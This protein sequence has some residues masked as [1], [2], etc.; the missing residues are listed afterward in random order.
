MRIFLDGERIYVGKLASNT[1]ISKKCQVDIGYPMY[2]GGGLSKSQRKVL[3]IADNAKLIQ[4]LLNTDE[5]SN[6]YQKHAIIE[7]CI[8]KSIKKKVKLSFSHDK[9]TSIICDKEIVKI[10]SIVPSKEDQAFMSPKKDDECQL[11]DELEKEK[12]KFLDELDEGLSSENE[13]ESEWDGDSDDGFKKA[14]KNPQQKKKTKRAKAKAVLNQPIVVPG[15]LQGELSEYE[16]IRADNIKERQDMLAALMANF[17][18]YKQDMG[19]GCKAPTSRK[20]PKVKKKVDPGML[21]RST[22]VLKAYLKVNHINPQEMNIVRKIMETRSEVLEWGE[23]NGMSKVDG[24]LEGASVSGESLFQPQ[25]EEV[26]FESSDS[27]LLKSAGCED[28]AIIYTPTKIRRDF[29]DMYSVHTPSPNF[30]VRNAKESELRRLSAAVH[31]A[32][33]LPTFSL[34]KKRL[35]AK[36]FELIMKFAGPGSALNLL[37]NRTG[38]Q[39]LKIWRNTSKAKDWFRGHELSG[40][41]DSEGFHRPDPPYCPFG[42]CHGKHSSLSTMELDLDLSLL[43]K[44]SIQ[45]FSESSAEANTTVADQQSDENVNDVDVRPKYQI[46]PSHD[47]TCTDVGSDALF[48]TLSESEL[49]KKCKELLG[50]TISLRKKLDFDNDMSTTKNINKNQKL[51][52]RRIDSL[53]DKNPAVKKTLS[54][55]VEIKCHVKGCFKRYSTFNGLSFHLKNCHP[56]GKE[57]TSNNYT[58]KSRCVIC[59][60]EVVALDKHMQNV[61]SKSI[62]K[63]CEECGQQISGSIQTHLDLCRKCKFC[64]KRINRKDRVESHL[65]ACQNRLMKAKKQMSQSSHNSCSTSEESCE[66]DQNLKDKDLNNVRLSGDHKG[67]ENLRMDELQNN[68]MKDPNES[69]DADESPVSQDLCHMDKA[70]SDGLNTG[71]VKGVHIEEFEN[72]ENSVSS[73]LAAEEIVYSLDSENEYGS[74]EDDALMRHIRLHNLPYVKRSPTLSDG[75]CWYDAVA[76]QITLHNIPNKPKDHVR[77][78]SAICRFIPFLPQSS[79]WIENIFGNDRSKFNKFI[80]RHQGDC[81]WTDDY[82]IICQATAL[83]LE[84]NIYIVGT[85]NMGQPTGF[86]IIEGTPESDKYPPLTIGYYQGEHYQSLEERLVFSETNTSGSEK[87]KSED[88][89][90]TVPNT[91]I[92][93]KAEMISHSCEDSVVQVEELGENEG[94]KN[95][96]DEQTARLKIKLEEDPYYRSEHE[97]DDS[98]EFT[99]FRRDNKDKIEKILQDI[100]QKEV[101]SCEGDQEFLDGFYKFLRETKNPHQMT[102]DFASVQEPSTY[103]TYVRC[104]KNDIFPCYRTYITPFD[105]QWLL[106][107]STPKHCSLA[108]FRKENLKDPIYVSPRILRL[109]LCKYPDVEQGWH[110]SIVLSTINHLMSYVE[111]TKRNDLDV[112]GREPLKK[113]MEYHAH[114]RACIDQRSMWKIA[115]KDKKKSVKSNKKIK[116]IK[117]PN[118]NAKILR[119]YKLWI[120]SP[121]RIESLETYLENDNLS[122]EQFTAFGHRVMSELLGVSGSRPVVLYRLTNGRY[123]SKVPGYMPY[124]VTEDDSVLE[125]E[126]EEMNIYR[127]VNP[128]TPPKELACIHQLENDVA[129]CPV[130]C[131]KRAEPDGWNIAVDWDKVLAKNGES[132]LHIPQMFKNLLDLYARKKEIFFKNKKPQH[133]TR[134]DWLEHEDTPFFLTSSGNAFSR[135]YFNEMSEFMDLAVQPLDLRRMVSTWAQ[136]HR[137]GAIRRAEEFALNHAA[138]VAQQSYLLN[139]QHPSQL[140]TQQ[141]VSEEGLLTSKLA[142]AI[143]L[144]RTA[145]ETEIAVQEDLMKERIDTETLKKA[146]VK[147][148]K[149]SSNNTLGP[150]KKVY[151]S[152]REILRSE[153]KKSIGVDLVDVRKTQKYLKWRNLLVR[154]VCSTQGSSGEEIRKVWIKL[155]RGEERYGIRHDRTSYLQKLKEGKIAQPFRKYLDRN[156]FISKALFHSF[157]LLKS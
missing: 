2:G 72:V 140:L 78:R 76:D 101:L 35:T 94:K 21:R 27:I 86:T 23:K 5:S 136:S 113:I 73:V 84:R 124:R 85:A 145:H 87:Q 75:N 133:V 103:R 64:G 130:N 114:T 89:K 13:S 119:K 70:K 45:E 57:S 144:H 156:S 104:L 11:D 121:R 53:E 138:P 60:I 54:E 15:A 24:A 49:R 68:L 43:K 77:L 100:D 9:D 14:A 126:D 111:E 17:A 47:S 157:R 55:L 30:K 142:D 22:R 110:R 62:W 125:E 149:R 93:R 97:D 122:G 66:T 56:Q 38:L 135:V 151:D 48:L 58:S 153:I 105:P 20:T 120:K 146:E 59:G 50:E 88:D 3:N 39:Y 41:E 10:D 155:Y 26:Q 34:G 123:Y 46:I 83:F 115:N 134:E 147:K 141:L 137:K 16:Q 118:R 150:R 71:V 42:H 4:N 95:L 117:N 90:N 33:N 25:E 44:N 36:D 143:S 52:K 96:L 74:Q 19:I 129:I 107:S 131:D 37:N 102:G 79:Q 148:R 106:D 12:Q 108:G 82:G 81:E 99:K 80:A 98:L 109:A 63:F 51:K 112:E 127:R 67:A 7:D 69:L 92:E 29:L 6:D 152:D 91:S 132:Y 31:C 65:R 128:N 61:H 32:E 139:Q 154:A 18:D 40:F 1:P 8:E 116:E 28:N